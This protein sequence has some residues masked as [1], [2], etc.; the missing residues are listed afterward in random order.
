MRQ[1]H[2]LVQAEKRILFV[3]PGALEPLR[4]ALPKSQLLGRRLVFDDDLDVIEHRDD[5]GRKAVQGANND[6]LEPLSARLLD[7][8]PDPVT[9]EVNC[10]SFGL[11]SP[12][13]GLGRSA[14][15]RSS[16]G[17]RSSL[18]TWSRG[19]CTAVG[20]ACHHLP[21]AP[22]PPAMIDSL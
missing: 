3:I 14:Y 13:L 17:Q 4:I 21:S 11:F 12:V 5:L 2:S 18:D 8:S 9:H 7:T 6:A 19:S 1:R 10:T 20:H 16:V 22:F 15:V